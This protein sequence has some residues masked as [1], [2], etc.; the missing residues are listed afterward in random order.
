MGAVDCHM[1]PCL[2]GS[3][4]RNAAASWPR[5]GPRSV[6][7]QQIPDVRNAYGR[8]AAGLSAKL[9]TLGSEPAGRTSERVLLPGLEW[10][11]GRFSDSVEGS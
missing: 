2:H 4:N 9:A 6:D 1:G 10:R 5:V 3:G 11:L 8:W 7:P